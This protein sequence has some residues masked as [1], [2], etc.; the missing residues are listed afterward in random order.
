MLIWQKFTKTKKVMT[1]FQSAFYLNSDVKWSG[2]EVD[3]L[4]RK[5]YDESFLT[6]IEAMK[7]L[8]TQSIPL[9]KAVS[10]FR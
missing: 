7:T 8:K 1:A 4:R 5:K 6:R 2:E 10:E 3:N 9:T